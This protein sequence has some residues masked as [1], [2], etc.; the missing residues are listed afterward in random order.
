MTTTTPP[1]DGRL[2]P[3]ALVLLISAA[4]AVTAL[5]IDLRVPQEH[6]DAIPM[7]PGWTGAVPGLALAWAG[8]VVL[9]HQRRHPVGWVLAVFGLWWCLDSAAASWLTFATLDQPPRAG[10][11]VAFWVYQ[12][13]G[14]GLLLVLPLVLLLFP[15][16]RLPSGRWRVAAVSGLLATTLLPLTLV[17]VPARVA[18][19]VAGEEGIPEAFR[20]LDLD[21]VSLPVPDGAW[22]VLLRTAFL[23]LA[24]S[25]VPVLAVVVHRYRTARG[26]DRVR[27]RWL[28]WAAVVDALLMLTLQLLPDVAGSWGLTLAVLLTSAAVVVGITRPEVVDVDRLLGG[29]VLY[30]VLL[31]ATFLLDLAVLGVAGWVVGGELS[32]NQALVVAVFVVAAVYAPLRHRLA[33]LVR[34]LA[35]GERDDPYAVVSGLARRL[36][37]STVSDEQL[38]AVAR[39]VADAFRTPYVGVEIRQ[40]TGERLLAEHGERPAATRALP[41]GYRGETVGRLLLPKDGVTAR[42]RPSDERLLADVVR[43]AAA[44]TRAAQLAEEL[45]RSRE[46]LVTAIEDERRRLRRDLHDGL[47]PRL[48]AVASRIDTARIVGDRSPEEAQRMLGLAREEVTG[49]LAE[50]RRLVHGLR[51]PALDDV[52]LVRAVRQQAEQLSSP[53]LT[54]EVE[55]PASLSGLPAA[56]EVAVFRIVSESL[57]NVLRHAGAGRCTVRLTP[58]PGRLVVE[59]VDDGRGIEAGTPAG[60]GLVSLRE[61]AEELGG[62]CEVTRVS[63]GGTRVRA[64]LPLPAPTLATAATTP[65]PGAAVGLAATEG[66]ADG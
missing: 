48:A 19:D 46:R 20:S 60:V 51:P 45:Q 37:E 28:L 61:R 66:G 31:L 36:E 1:P 17:A 29:T 30:A 5:V 12:R 9:R 49:M 62:R 55:A 47:G 27:M 44:A 43:Q 34:R 3:G 7:E 41:V 38:L 16:G 10:A 13:L 8:A 2:R 22:S 65:G 15:D 11:S 50:V 23:A 32:G 14:A 24:F 35:L 21:A 42:L 33:R 52:G 58:E 6:R 63:G 25:L 40:T 18:Q 26:L 53:S 39:A 54:V 64:V 56:V 59:V 57:A 4:A